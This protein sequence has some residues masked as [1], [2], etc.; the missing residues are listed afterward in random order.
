MKSNGAIVSCL[1]GCAPQ[2]FHEYLEWQRVCAELVQ[3]ALQV[4]EDFRRNGGFVGGFQRIFAV[5]VNQGDA[6]IVAA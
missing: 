6:V 5:V 3:L 4:G 1:P 2:Y